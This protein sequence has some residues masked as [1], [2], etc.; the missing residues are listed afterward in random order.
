MFANGG[1]IDSDATEVEVRLASPADALSLARLRYEFRSSFHNTVEHELAFVERCTAWMQEQLRRQSHWRC[2]I[3][4]W[5]QTPVGNIW[6][7]LVEKIPNPLAESESYVYLTN[8]Y[9]REE[10]RGHGIGS[11]LLSEALAWSRS[12]NAQMVI[13]WP[14]EQSKPFYMRNGFAHARDVMQLS[15]DGVTNRNNESSNETPF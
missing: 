8:F 1:S 2:W 11:R 6:V 12:R 9:V 4:E 5:Q 10:H 15:I 3:A 13:L 7:Q 14:T